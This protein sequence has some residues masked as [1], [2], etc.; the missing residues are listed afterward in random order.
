M[1]NRLNIEVSKNLDSLNL[2]LR[3]EIEELRCLILSANENLEEN[4]KWNG[5]NYHIKDA[6]RITMKLQPTKQIQIIFHCG[7][8]TQAQPQEKLLANDFG[9][10]DWKSNDRAVLTLENEEDIQLNKEK[11]T[12][13]IQNWLATSI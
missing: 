12:S 8:K 13:L 7:A 11:I 1:N 2:P 4:T 5:P 9:L 10:L 6:D 3:K